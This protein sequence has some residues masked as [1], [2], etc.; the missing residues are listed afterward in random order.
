MILRRDDG[1][2]AILPSAVEDFARLCRIVQEETFRVMW[3]R[4]WRQFSEG[5][6]VKFGELALSLAGVHR[7][8]DLLAWYNLDDVL[9]Q[10]G[11]LIIRSKRL[12]RAWQETALHLVANPHIFAALLLIGPPA[13]E[14]ADEN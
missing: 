12:R 14:E 6:R 10:N 4:I 3:P 7:E 9:I 2:E 11:K 1:A 5:L 13:V 8:A